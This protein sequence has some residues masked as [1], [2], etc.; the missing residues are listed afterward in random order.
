[1]SMTASVVAYT[2]APE[3]AEELRRRVHEHP[4]P[5]ARQA[6]GHRGF[7]LMAEPAQARSA[8]HRQRWPLR[9]VGRVVALST[10]AEQSRPHT[11]FGRKL[12]M[13]LAGG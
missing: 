12:G 5:S 13:H 2:V 3:Y 1:M 9:G 11:D 10:F 8:R 4:V 6:R 7:P